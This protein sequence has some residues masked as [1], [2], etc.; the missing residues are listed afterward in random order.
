MTSFSRMI[1]FSTL[2]TKCSY[3]DGCRTRMEYKYIENATME[4]NQALVERDEETFLGT[5]I[6]AHN[7]KNVHPVLVYESM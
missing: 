7:V 1:E 2:E 3:L 4:L 6:L 5:T